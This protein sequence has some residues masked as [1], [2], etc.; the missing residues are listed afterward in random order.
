L[1]FFVSLAGAG[2]AW[3]VAVVAVVLVERGA[4][5]VKLVGLVL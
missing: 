5:L 1:G 4:L 2:A 3:T